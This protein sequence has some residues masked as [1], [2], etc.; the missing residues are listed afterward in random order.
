M[1]NP[2][3]YP[4]VS[5]DAVLGEASFRPFYGVQCLFLSLKKYVELVRQVGDAAQHI[6]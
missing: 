3:R 1:H 6:D 5:S 2:E 4:F